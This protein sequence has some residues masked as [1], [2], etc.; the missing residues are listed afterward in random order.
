MNEFKK[1]VDKLLGDI[2]ERKQ[3]MGFARGRAKKVI[4]NFEKCINEINEALSQLD[5][6]VNTSINLSEHS[7]NGS[8]IL[9]YS[10]NGYPNIGSIIKNKYDTVFV[11]DYERNIIKAYS[12]IFKD[13]DD[14]R[15]FDEEYEVVELD[16]DM[17]NEIMLNEFKKI[18]SLIEKEY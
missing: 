4:A 13:D 7:K 18:L 17:H 5:Y 8:Y 9:V 10:Y 3:S 1:E 15:E 6:V 2:E 11:F 14:N 16:E 12:G